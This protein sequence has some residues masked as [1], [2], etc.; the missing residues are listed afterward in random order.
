M[1][2]KKSTKE[3]L[4]DSA[5]E[6]F[7]QHSIEEITVADIAANCNIVQEHSIIIFG[8][9]TNLLHGPTRINWKNISKDA[10]Q[11]SVFRDLCDIQPRSYMIMPIFLSMYL[12]IK[13]RTVFKKVF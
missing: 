5:L 3:L 7:S 13:D 11:K 10:H 4:V 9:N 12:L 1:I 2:T 6:L 8:I